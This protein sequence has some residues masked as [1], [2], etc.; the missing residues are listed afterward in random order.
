MPL[1]QGREYK[2][3]GQDQEAFV[4]DAENIIEL[5]A[6]SWVVFSTH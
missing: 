1:S 3:L 6:H 5:G 4:A 2:V